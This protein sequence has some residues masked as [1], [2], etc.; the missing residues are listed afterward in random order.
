MSGAGHLMPM[1]EVETGNGR[2]IERTRQA[3]RGCIRIVATSVADQRDLS[4]VSTL[5]PGA[6]AQGH[7]QPGAQMCRQNNR[8]GLYMS[9]DVTSPM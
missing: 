2:E 8:K 4:N 5:A 7:Q 6:I 3:P 9:H 1:L